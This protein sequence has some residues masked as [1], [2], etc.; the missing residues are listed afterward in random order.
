MRTGWC[1]RHTARVVGAWGTGG[2]VTRLRKA[3]GVRTQDMDGVGR[4]TSG[5]GPPV[6][7]AAAT[8]LWWLSG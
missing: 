4:P 8:V 3:E 5:G 1:T 2:T 7:E 6:E